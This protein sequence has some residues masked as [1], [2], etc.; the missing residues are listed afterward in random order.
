MLP[1]LLALACN[2]P[3]DDTD[4]EPF[5]PTLPTADCDNPG[6]DWLSSE[7]MGEIVDWEYID[8]AS[9]PSTTIDFFLELAGLEDLTPVPYGLEVYRVR[10]LTQD[11]GETIETTGILSFPDVE[12]A[13]SFPTLLWV[14]PTMGFADDCA[15]SGGPLELITGTALLASFGYAVTAPDLLGMNGWGTPSGFLH[16]YVVP[17]PTAVASLDAV[18]AL[19]RFAE[20]EGEAPPIEASPESRTVFIGASEGGFGTLWADRYAEGYAPEIDLIAVVASVPPSDVYGLAQAAAETHGPPTEGLA[21]I[22]VTNRLW[23]GRTVPLSEVLTDEPPA[24]LASTLE[25]AMAQAC[26]GGDNPLDDL[27]TV[28]SIFQPAFRTALLADDRE[29]IEPWSCY[30]ATATLA[31]SAVP[32]GSDAPVLYQ[33]AENDELVLTAVGRADVPRLCEAGYAIDY[34]ECAGTD[35][36]SGAT[37]S[38]QRQLEWLEDRLAG[39]PLTETCVVGAPVDCTQ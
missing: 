8:D 3:V 26:S 16:P 1:L 24:M 14:R 35:H 25:S 18:R 4:E 32:R 38:L 33:V 19:W 30:L 12:D 31:E 9:V 20:G 15:P 37:Q 29:G 13:S 36:V 39:V 10:Y 23:Y 6:Y 5:V 17:E 34:L 21:G 22:L 11:R 28:E 2:P 7:R 27:D